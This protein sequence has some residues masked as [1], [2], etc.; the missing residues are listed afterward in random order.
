MKDLS[1]INYK[2]MS[3]SL[4]TILCCLISMLIVAGCGKTADEEDLSESIGTAIT[5]PSSVES[6]IDDDTITPIIIEETEVPD[7]DVCGVWVKDSLEYTFNED[8]TGM[9]RDIVS[10]DCITY[11]YVVTEISGNACITIKYDEYD[12]ELNFHYF[13]V[14]ED[15]LMLGDYAF[16][17]V[18]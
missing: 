5:E 11:T 15:E 2:K 14:S 7:Y 6:N 16:E 13:F 18:K 9:K 10:D 1:R 3:I 12:T 4:I 8:N 17:R